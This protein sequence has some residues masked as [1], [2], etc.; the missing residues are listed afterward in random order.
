MRSSLCGLHWRVGLA[1]VVGL[2]VFALGARSVAAQEAG[3]LGQVTDESGG[4]LPGVTTTATSPA[5][6]LPQVTA[7]TNELGEYR[8]SPLP[9]G[10]YTV[11]YALPGFQT[12]RREGLRLTVGFTAK[13]DV[14]LKVSALAETVTVSGAAP[15]VDVT[16]SSSSTRLT[17]ETLEL[18]P[19]NRSNYLALLAQA[20]GTRANIDV[21]G[22]NFNASL[23]F[24]ALGQV[25]ESWQSIE[26]IVTTA[27]KATQSGNYI[28]YTT[29]EE[30]K[31]QTIGSDA[32]VPNRGIVINAIV[33]SGSNEFHGGAFYAYT[34]HQFEGANIDDALRAQGI[35]KSSKL[36]LRDDISG[37]FGGPLKRNKLWFYGSAR[38]RR[39]RASIVACFQPD[40]SP[41]ID[42][43]EQPSG[44]VKVSYQLNPANRIIGFSQWVLKVNNAGA[45]RLVAWE[46]RTK[47][48]PMQTMPKAEWQGVKGNS[49]VASAQIG[50]WRS[51]TR[52]GF[53]NEKVATIDLVTA[54]VTGAN[55]SSGEHNEE[56]RIG[57]KGVVSWYKP[58]W[59][60]GNHQIKAGFDY[61]SAG[62]NRR[63]DSRG[64]AGNYQLQFRRGVP[65]QIAV[66]NYPVDPHET[67]HYLGT[68]VQDSWTIA[69]RLTLNLGVRWAYD[70]AFAPELC[71]EA[72]EPPGHVAYPAQCFGRIDLPIWKPVSPRLRAVYDVT[73]DGKTVVKG[74]WGRFHHM[75]VTDEIQVVDRNVKSTT[76]YRWRDLNG[77]RLYD[78]GEV[79]LDPNGPDFISRGLLGLTGPLANG[80]INPK[81]EEPWTDEYTLQVERE[82][83]PDF[84][85]RVTGAYSRALNQ[86]RLEN[87]LRPYE[88]YTIPVT[89]RDPGP[90]GIVGTADDPGGSITYYEF[91]ATLAGLAFQAPMIVNDPKA[92]QTYRTI[93]VAVTKRLSNRWQFMASYS[94]TRKHIP[95]P[96][97]VGGGVGPAFNSKDPN[98]EIFAADATWDKSGRVSGSYLFP[99]D[100]LA[101]ANFEH[102][103]GNAFART[104]NFT[105]GRTIPSI[106]LKVEPL[107]SVRLPDL[108]LLD[109]RVEKRISLRG[110]QNLTGRF[111]LYNA[112]NSNAV[113]AQTVLSG[114]NF[115]KATA[116][117]SP[118]IAEL[119]LSYSF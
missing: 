111:N 93:E 30:A 82:L 86:Y 34:N 78:A 74:G 48:R 62:G 80:V 20:P 36:D 25:G 101:S 84:A 2:S 69:R 43:Q 39:S 33:K 31:I 106:T 16:A 63:Q 1:A 107:G 8:L 76:V 47:Q 91:P 54:E 57:T 5:L 73:G 51:W 13:V 46:S 12:V 64:A 11:E 110:H 17:K 50:A 67:I 92:N 65:S 81:E 18:I 108:N 4:V 89:N 21:G 23:D 109:L 66:G 90:D 85:V 75:R 102:R 60:G 96:I 103:N 40:G 22:D 105:G 41:C 113:T 77:N 7:V 116:I 49:L 38:N 100:V 70:K 52:V 10:T 45:S 55:F 29:L 97:N 3:I 37:E 35:T 104:V 44:T 32:E 59:L 72:A 99:G 6:Q 83:M 117:I 58:D 68:Y 118:R 71:R 15:V 24:R 14:V 95:L 119:S 112:L 114:P 61:T 56:Y 53:W 9:I 87:S 79:N 115:G 94:A 19:T 98:A 42:T 26:G 28:D 88:T 27:A